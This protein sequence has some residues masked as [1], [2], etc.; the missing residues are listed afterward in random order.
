MWLCGCCIPSSDDSDTEPLVANETGSPIDT[1]G[2]QIG[3]SDQN[4]E[5]V[6]VRE[7]QISDGK[8][9]KIVVS[10]HDE[11]IV[12]DVIEP[13]ESVVDPTLGKEYDI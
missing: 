2:L 9:V 12:E 8:N 10:D 5:I 7:S 4:V 3:V 1:R 6:V 13:E 11:E